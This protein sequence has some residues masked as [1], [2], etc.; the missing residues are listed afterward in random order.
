MTKVEGLNG[1][2]IAKNRRECPKQTVEARL[3]REGRLLRTP[4]PCRKVGS[5]QEVTNIYLEV[6][7]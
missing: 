1:P 6:I 7:S 4:Y 3:L 2:F 5:W